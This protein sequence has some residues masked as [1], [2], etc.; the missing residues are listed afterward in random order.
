MSEREDA[1]EIPAMSFA[2]SGGGRSFQVEGPVTAKA[3]R[4]VRA[5]LARGTN[6]SKRSIERKGR[7]DEAERG[8]G[9]RAE[10]YLGASPNWDLDT[11]RRTLYWI[12]EVIG[13]Q[14][15]TSVIY[16]EIWEN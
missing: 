12:R 9:I 11:K 14:C 6:R 10:R 2:R 3:L 4:W 1:G 13:S 16:V 15:R 8:L 5:V 7:P